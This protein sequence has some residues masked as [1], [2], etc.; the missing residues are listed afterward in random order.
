MYDIPACSFGIYLLQEFILRILF[1][2]T[3]FSIIIS[4]YALLWVTTLITLFLPYALT[5]L[6]RQTK[7]GRM[8]V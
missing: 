3:S 8:L 5:S 4:Q 1:Y 2:H 7:C 6:R